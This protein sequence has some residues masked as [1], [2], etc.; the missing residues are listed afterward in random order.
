[1]NKWQL[2]TMQPIFKAVLYTTTNCLYQVWLK[3]LL[4][5][6]QTHTKQAWMLNYIVILDR[7]DIRML[8]LIGIR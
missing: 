7:N 3:H 6:S 2:N 1:M 8:I 4:H 5:T